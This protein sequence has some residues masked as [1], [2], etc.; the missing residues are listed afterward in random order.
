MGVYAK[1]AGASDILE[2]IRY[3]HSFVTYA[4]NG[5]TIELRAEDWIMGN[6]VPW[7]EH[8][9]LQIVCRHLQTGDVVRLITAEKEQVLFQAPT[10][11]NVDL[12]FK[13]EAPGFARVEILRSFLP[14]LPVLPALLSN[15]IFFDA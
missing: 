4:P 2:A 6:S 10:P 7:K 1:S 13:M 14:G 8:R 11:G 3:G 9:H 15:P 5:P 12:T